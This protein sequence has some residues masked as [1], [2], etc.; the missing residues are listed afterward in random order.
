MIDLGVELAD[1]GRARTEQPPFTI[2]SLH[3]MKVRLW[4]G[5]GLNLGPLA[6]LQAQGFNAEPPPGFTGPM[7]RMQPGDG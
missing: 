5:G 1:Y 6:G 3:D 2:A 7:M 4:T